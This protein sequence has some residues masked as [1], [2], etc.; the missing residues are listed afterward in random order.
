MSNQDLGYWTGSI[1]YQPNWSP[2]PI[3]C[4]FGQTDANGVD[5]LW[6]QM[7]GWDSPPVVGTVVQRTS[8]HGGWP[9]EQYFTARTITLTVQASAP[10]QAAR[11]VARAALQA[12]LPVN[13]LA[14][15][16]YN[17]PV[18]KTVM[19]RRASQIIETNVT[20]TDTQFACVL[21]APDPRKYSAVVKSLVTTM[22][23]TTYG[24]T[25]PW[26]MPMTLPAQPLSGS[27]SAINAGNFETRPIITVAGPLSNPSI[28]HVED[29]RFISFTGMTLGA[30][31][32]LVVDTDARISTLNGAYRTADLTSWWW[33]LQPG[34]HTIML[35]GNTTGAATMTVTYSDAWI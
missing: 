20:L 25:S 26:T 9:T 24:V 10:T 17:E 14:L 33:V 23:N 11:D 35:G 19:V 16:T 27:V 3:A 22:Q 13:E 34:S 7:Q 6:M 31:D 18:P 12:C 4:Q 28:M 21:I 29:G 2:A 1:S 32:R 8:D 15:L 30:G 5:W